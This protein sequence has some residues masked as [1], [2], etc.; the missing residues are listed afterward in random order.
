MNNVFVVIAQVNRAPG[1]AVMT[2]LVDRLLPIVRDD[3]I[4]EAEQVRDMG[5]ERFQVLSND[6]GADENAAAIAGFLDIDRAAGAAL[7]AHLDLR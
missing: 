7:I 2:S 6:Q 1:L 4:H 3:L 5:F